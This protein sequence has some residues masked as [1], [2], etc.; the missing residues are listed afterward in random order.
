MIRFILPASRPS[1]RSACMPVPNI[2]NKIPKTQHPLRLHARGEA[3]PPGVTQ[4]GP[5]LCPHA[6]GDAGTAPL[7]T[8]TVLGQLN[9]RTRLN[10]QYNVCCHAVGSLVCGTQ[11]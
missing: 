11:L 9:H 2:P 3:A 7:Y 1:S 5:M 10:Y 4:R 6:G 8:L